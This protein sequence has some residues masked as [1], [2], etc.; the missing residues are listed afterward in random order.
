MS[1][2]LVGLALEAEGLKPIEKLV[3]VILADHGNQDGTAWPK[4]SSIAAKAGIKLRYV[5]VVMERLEKLGY[6]IRESRID[7]R[8]RQTSNNYILNFNRGVHYS[9]GGP[10][11]IAQGDLAPQCKGEGAPQRKVITLNRKN[12]QAKGNNTTV[13]RTREEA[14]LG[15]KDSP[16][17]EDDEWN[18]DTEAFRKRWF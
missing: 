15:P 5:S 10:C 3:L 7:Q 14:P 8:G 1:S 13:T 12:E 16:L 11:T 2:K 9:A 18:P 6:V 17:D 4:R